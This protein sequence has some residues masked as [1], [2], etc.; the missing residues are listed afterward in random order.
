M[1]K[2]MCLVKM[3]TL[4]QRHGVR[5]GNGEDEDKKNMRHELH[6]FANKN[7]HYYQDSKSYKLSFMNERL[8][9]WSAWRI[10]KLTLTSLGT[11]ME[12]YAG[13]SP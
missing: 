4:K 2:A 3:Y 11:P 6:N 8:T 13:L 10:S 9:K 7:P 5:G 12:S 1:A